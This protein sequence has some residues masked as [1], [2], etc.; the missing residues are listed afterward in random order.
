[1]KIKAIII[2]II[3]TLALFVFLLPRNESDS[4]MIGE[5]TID[6]DE[7]IKQM[8]LAGYMPESFEDKKETERLLREK[9]FSPE[10]TISVS[11]NS[12]TVVT[13]DSETQFSY[14]VEEK[15]VHWALISTEDSEFYTRWKFTNPN[16]VHVT[17]QNPNGVIVNSTMVLVRKITGQDES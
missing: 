3:L 2:T 12:C 17:Y 9:V 14:T 4:R 7:S 8:Y 13:S 11:H 5:W 10:K 15:G 1:M 6:A 16:R